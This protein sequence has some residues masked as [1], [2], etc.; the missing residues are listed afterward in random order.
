MDDHSW[1]YQDSLKGLFMEDYC[2][3]NEG[4]INFILYNPKNIIRGR[5]RC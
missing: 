1:M 5:I 4:F 2:K 3:E